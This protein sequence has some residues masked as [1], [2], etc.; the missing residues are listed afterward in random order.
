M[1]ANTPSN[2]EATYQ[3]QSE[4]VVYGN[5]DLLLGAEVAFGRLDGGVAEQEL[6]LFD[7]SAVLAAE[8]GA[9]AAEVVRPEALDPDLPGACSTTD[10]TAQ[11]LMLALT[12]PP[13][14]TARSS[15][16]SSTPAAVIQVL[17]PCL[18]QAGIA[19]VRTRRP[20]PS[21]SASTHR[22]SRNWMVSTSSTASS[23]GARRS[24]PAWPGGRNPACP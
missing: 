12:L 15:L 20:L 14:V 17:I 4:V 6:D 8:L 10:Q 1:I 21:R 9:S 7:I 13:L 2:E 19:T 18:T 11:P 5:L 16:P 22:P 3:L 23:S 24:R